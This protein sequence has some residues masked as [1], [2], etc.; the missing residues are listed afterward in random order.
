[1]DRK[2]QSNANARPHLGVGWSFPVRPQG[3]RLAYAE[4]EEDVEQAIG[5]ILET[6][7]NERIMR[8]HF[9]GELHNYLFEGNSSVT[10]RSLEETVKQALREWEPR[11]TVE[12]VTA[13]LAPKEPNL[14][15][16]AIDY[17][18]RRTNVFYNRVY[19]FY[20]TEAG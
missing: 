12:G 2:E 4:Y 7:R 19:P 1:M 5:I 18:V 3:G 20:L 14:L 11:I 6:A 13:S 8:P 15:F 17:V 9:G 10:H 16:L